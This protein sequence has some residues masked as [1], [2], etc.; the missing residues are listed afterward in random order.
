MHAFAEPG[1][2]GLRDEIGTIFFFL[3]RGGFLWIF[4]TL[5]RV[6]G[7]AAIGLVNVPWKRKKSETFSLSK[8]IQ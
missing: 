3:Y 7:K 1:K 2:R 5:K 6:C 8:F 4:L